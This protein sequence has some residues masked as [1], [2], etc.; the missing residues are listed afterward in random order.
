MKG[1]PTDPR[2]AATRGAVEKETEKE[3]MEEEWL[4]V[5]VIQGG[6]AGGDW[7]V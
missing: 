6:Q 2:L 4:A 7:I 5:D 3:R 1:A